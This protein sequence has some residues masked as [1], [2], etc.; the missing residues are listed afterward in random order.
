MSRD[1]DRAPHVRWEIV[2]PFLVFVLHSLLFRSWLIDDAGISFAYAR[3]LIHGHGLV[4]QAGV[5]PVE[6][7]SNPLWTLL[8]APL[9]VSDPVDPTWAV[10]CVSLSL[11][12]VTFV[13]VSGVNRRLFADPWWSRM[14]TAAA[15]TSLSIN[16]SFVAWTT[17]GLENPLY[18]FLSALYCF[19]TI[20]YVTSGSPGG[21]RGVACT[22]LC[23]SGLALTRPDGVLFFAAFP[24]VLFI[25]ALREPSLWKKQ[26]EA[27]GLFTAFSVLPTAAYLAFRLAYFGDILP[28]TYYAKGGPSL[29]DF[30]RLLLLGRDYVV[31][32]YDLFFGM[33]S[34]AAGILMLAVPVVGAYLLLGRKRASVLVCLF[35][36]LFCSW[37]VYCLLPGDWMGE[38]RFGTPFFLAFYLVLFASVSDVLLGVAAASRVSRAAFLAVAVGLLLSS[39]V[40]YLPRSV[41]FARDPAAPFKLVAQRSGE[42]FNEYA[43][44]LAISDASF[45]APDLG[46]TLYFSR[47]RVYDLT[48]LCDRRLA[49]LI[50]APDRTPLRDYVFGELR[51]TFLHVH[52]PWS[53]VSGLHQ[54]PRLER[55]YAAIWETPTHGDRE[56]LSGD[57]VL[58]AAVVDERAFQRLREAL[59][60]STEQDL[61]SGEVKAAPFPRG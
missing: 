60:S 47:H 55:L 26:V 54:D 24:V 7:F 21:R 46:G 56:V 40:V 4:S 29:E 12:L 52:G 2:F 53:V 38:F 34:W 49:R 8:L 33:F 23:V 45:L 16:T 59:R 5:A 18:A 50:S 19:L 41:E 36:V 10:K 14:T 13:L 11:V 61:A 51:P 15:L 43:E 1:P 20:R 30:F 44:K 27:F 25:L 28:N 22:G 48:G 35:P 3:N 57:Y 37:S 39:A 9:F 17:S 58:K 6:G 31:K 32:T 42:R